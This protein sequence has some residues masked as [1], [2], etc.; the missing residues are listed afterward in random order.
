MKKIIMR[1]VPT[2]EIEL[3]DVKDTDLIGVEFYGGNR[4]QI[5]KVSLGAYVSVAVGKK[6]YD[7]L[8]TGTTPKSL[9]YK[10]SDK[11]GAYVFD[12]PREL[13]EWLIENLK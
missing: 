10:L 7:N 4:S 5:V 11:M 12:S 8:V 2:T 13:G 9:L 1:E 6:G 3:N